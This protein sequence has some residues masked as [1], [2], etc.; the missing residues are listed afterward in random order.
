MNPPISDRVQ[1]N[2]DSIAELEQDFLRQ[3]STVACLGDR[4]A[5]FASSPYFIL[6]H[7]VWISGWILANTFD[8]FG[9]VQFDPYPFCFLALC[10][11]SEA[12]LLSMFV[13]MSQQRQTRQ[14]DQ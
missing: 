1:Q 3:R 12:A 5:E 4:I 2:I 10:L 9:A 13:L 7:V 8:C 14:A 11:A 6:G